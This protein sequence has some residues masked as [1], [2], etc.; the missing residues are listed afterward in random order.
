M[1]CRESPSAICMEW[2]DGGRSGEGGVCEAEK[3]GVIQRTAIHTHTHT[4]HIRITHTHTRSLAVADTP[5]GR[6]DV[7]VSRL[8]LLLMGPV[9]IFVGP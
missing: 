9:E 7:K 5:S 6:L 4:S 1:Q 3:G 8:L 2:R